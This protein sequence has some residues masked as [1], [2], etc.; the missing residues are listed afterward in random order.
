MSHMPLRLL[1]W[2]V[3]S[4]VVCGWV[5]S[6]CA[7][8]TKPPAVVASRRGLDWTAHQRHDYA[9]EMSSRYG[10]DGAEA[11]FDFRL[12]ATA[13][14]I[15]LSHGAKQT[16][17]LLSLHDARITARQ[18]GSEAAGV[19]QI[20]SQL[21]KPYLFTIIDGRLGSSHITKGSNAMVVGVMKTLA[22][23]LQFGPVDPAVQS[24]KSDEYD[25]TGAYVAEYRREASDP[26]RVA[27]RKTHYDRLIAAPQLRLGVPGIPPPK[28]LESDVRLELGASG[29]RK[30]DS[31]ET[32][33]TVMTPGTSLHSTTAITLSLR[34]TTA[35]APLD[36]SRLE[37]DMVAL[38]VD[39]PYQSPG[40]PINMDAA[41]IGGMSLDQ[42]I[43]G[44]DAQA[45]QRDGVELVDSES[46]NKAADDRIEQGQAWLGQ[47][48]R[49][50]TALAATFRSDPTSIERA[51]A[52]IRKPVKA[53]MVI[54][55]ALAA[56]G[57]GASLGLLIKLTH[58]QDIPDKLRRAC[59]FSLSRTPTPTPAAVAE[60][61]GWLREPKRASMAVY[62]LGTY[63]RR[64]QEQGGAA[65]ARRITQLLLT[66]LGT[67]KG[68]SERVDLL[69]GLSNSGDASALSA[70]RP[71]LGAA[72]EE[73]RSAGVLAV[74]LMAHP[75]IDA[76][77]AER[78]DHDTSPKVRAA[79]LQATQNRS[80][81]PILAT[82]L[83]HFVRN[84]PNAAERRYDGSKRLRN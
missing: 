42:I 8:E 43:A 26:S 68:V 84:E 21:E 72:R 80:P 9:L 14:L 44:L 77:I 59:A 76:L 66:R 61:E 65:E 81:S 79:A 34:A 3:F 73:L 35:A 78:L 36:R 27:K 49:L 7:D 1:S 47:E 74:R 40:G 83:A 63:A 60:V 6:A 37:S 12:Q 51:E 56:A 19:D 20:A 33:E 64:L 46:G 5:V 18:S 58:A 52:W 2:S 67:A 69:Q 30:L 28:V 10:Q 54:V 25:A 41:K 70:V 82:A 45:D 22:S 32:V 15:V 11:L 31:R 50:F 39:E 24:W 29:I 71:Y 57:N 23:N 55:N 53:H 17:F 13:S 38:K 48:R 75:E 62:G 4:V 16:E